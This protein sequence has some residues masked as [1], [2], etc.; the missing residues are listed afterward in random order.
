MKQKLWNVSDYCEN[1]I[2]FEM[3]ALHQGEG[4]W[5]L[6][7]LRWLLTTSYVDHGHVVKQFS[8]NNEMWMSLVTHFKTSC[9]ST[10]DWLSA[11]WPLQGEGTSSFFCLESCL[12][13][14]HNVIITGDDDDFDFTD[15]DLIIE[16]P[17]PKKKRKWKRPTKAY[18]RKHTTAGLVEDGLRISRCIHK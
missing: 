4:R 13:M 2:V 9:T 7:K 5:V 18:N 8:E 1:T 14:I 10:I 3:E 11:V 17:P 16:E 6:F 12:R 15:N